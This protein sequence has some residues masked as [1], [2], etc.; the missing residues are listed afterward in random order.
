VGKKSWY[1]TPH[2]CT[3]CERL[4]F[5]I[6]QEKG[7]GSPPFWILILWT[8]KNRILVLHPLVRG[9]PCFLTPGKKAILV[10]MILVFQTP[11]K[12]PQWFTFL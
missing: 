1:F 8:L 3:L 5:F 4:L 10:R 2:P 12:P 9:D 7:F 6:L 11:G